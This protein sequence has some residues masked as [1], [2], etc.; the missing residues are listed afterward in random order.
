MMVWGANLRKERHD[1]MAESVRTKYGL[2][3]V[4]RER[5]QNDYMKESVMNEAERRRI[6]KYRNM[7]LVWVHDHFAEK[8]MPPPC[9]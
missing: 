1:N 9:E 3:E 5:M 4:E 2:W 8:M 7:F 6:D